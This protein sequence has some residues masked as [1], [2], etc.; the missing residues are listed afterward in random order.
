MRAPVPAIALMAVLAFSG[1]KGAEAPQPA[2]GFDAFWTKFR[3]AA[4]QG[5]MGEVADLTHLPL[6]VG[7]EDDQDHAR[8]VSRAA[9]Q[10]YFRTELACQSI[11]G[12]SNL[13]M[14]RRKVRPDGRFDFHDGRRATVGA[15]SFTREGGRWR[16]TLLNLGDPGEHKSIAQGRCP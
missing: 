12:G 2:D 7:F 16:L 10:A 13:A 15:Y 5:D 11:D 3:Q 8:S 9:F 4:L 1:A 14:I 6:Q